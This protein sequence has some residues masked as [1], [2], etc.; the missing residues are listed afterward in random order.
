MPV[1][2]EVEEEPGPAVFAGCQ[3][4]VRE[5]EVGLMNFERMPAIGAA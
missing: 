5:V 2:V 4:P 1:V 3:E